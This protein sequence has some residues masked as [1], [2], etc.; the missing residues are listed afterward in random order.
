[1]SLFDKTYK[2]IVQ[3]QSF[4]FILSVQ[5]L[6]IITRFKSLTAFQPQK[7]RIFVSNRELCQQIIF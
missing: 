6:N 4:V 3:R 2:F 1:M 7:T 5:S